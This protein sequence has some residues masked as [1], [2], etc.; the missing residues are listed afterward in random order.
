MSDEEVTPPV[1]EVVPAVEEV[2]SSLPST[3]KVVENIKEILASETPA[4]NDLV[5]KVVREVRESRPAPVENNLENRINELE[6]KLNTVI[7]VLIIKKP[8]GAEQVY[9]AWKKM[10]SY[11]Y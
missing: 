1:E 7:E 11:Q 5:R 4:D 2:M 8:T 10:L 6:E 3:E 9:D